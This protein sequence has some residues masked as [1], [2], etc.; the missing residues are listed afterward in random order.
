MF[1]GRSDTA[2]VSVEYA[3]KRLRMSP[4]TIYRNLQDIPHVRVGTYIRIPCQWLFLEPP[5]TRV[6]KGSLEPA[7]YQPYLP[8]EVTDKR[9]WRNTGHIVDPY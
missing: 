8:F 3:A 7:P 1:Y 4:W 6:F 2:Y 5:R 9:R